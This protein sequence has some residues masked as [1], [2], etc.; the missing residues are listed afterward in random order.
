MRGVAGAA[1][2]EDS[3]FVGDPLG[4][5]VLA[6]AKVI[7][8]HQE[9]EDEDDRNERV[10]GEWDQLDLLCGDWHGGLF[11]TRKWSFRYPYNLA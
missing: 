3:A 2:R 1:G 8:C 6:G 4:S 9:G 7:G 10:D 5:R 11:T